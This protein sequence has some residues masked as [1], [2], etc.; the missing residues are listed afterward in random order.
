MLTA[1]EIRRG[2]II[3]M[4]GVLFSV[5]EFQHITPGNWR[6]MVQ[7]K[8]RNLKTGSIINHRFGSTDKVDDVTLE[9]KKCQYLYKDGGAFVFM[10]SE[11]FEQFNMIQE[12]L[13][14]SMGYI[15]PNTDVIV[16]FYEGS[17]MGVELPANVVLK[18]TY[19]EPGLR[20]NTVT[21]V[22]KPATLETGLETKVPLFIDTGEMIRVDCVSGEFVERV[23]LPVSA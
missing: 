1:T 15:L 6:G 18:V 9:R 7:S 19:T 3:R 2:T 20:G 16:V 21:N 13:G 22:F 17:P 8:L 11:S 5:V 12:I 4:D 14:D 10:D 23:N